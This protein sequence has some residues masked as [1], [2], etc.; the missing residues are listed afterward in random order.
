M[1][2]DSVRTQVLLAMVCIA[3]VFQ[4]VAQSASDFDRALAEFRAGK[5][6][7][8][9]TTFATIESAAPGSTDALL[10]RAKALVHLE[11]FS[12]ADQALRSYLQAHGNSSDALYMLGFVLNRENHAADSLTIYTQA[13]AMNPPTSD[14]LKIVGLDYVLL[15]DYADAIRWLEKS[16]AI[17]GK[18]KDAWYYLGRAYYTQSQLFKARAAFST[19]L[20]LDPR[21][22]KAQNGLG[23]IFESDAQPAAALDAYRKA[24]ALDEGNPRRSEQPYV[25]LGSLLLD[26]GQSQNA[27]RP[28]ETAVQLAPDNAYCRMRL[29]TA[30]FRVGKMDQAQLQLEKAT[31][32]DPENPAAHYQLGKVYKSTDQLDRAKA[33]FDRTE[34]LQSRAAVPRVPASEH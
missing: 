4:G 30:Y 16:V 15:N 9:A 33:E 34:E 31:Q 17:D 13:A 25:N 32:L 8:A 21:D 14:D 19:A 29:G 1:S 20:Q 2:T 24:I 10:Y 26:E 6:A 28:L 11:D 23:L 7:E 18:N 22:S 3:G 12:A 5:Y 27:I